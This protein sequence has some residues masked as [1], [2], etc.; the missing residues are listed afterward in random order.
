MAAAISAEQDKVVVEVT[1]DATHQTIAILQDQSIDI[2]TVEPTAGP[3]PRSVSC[4]H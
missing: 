3:F 4:P 1:E 2:A